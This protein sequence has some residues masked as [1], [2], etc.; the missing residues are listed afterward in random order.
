MPNEGG[1][2]N[3]DSKFVAIATFLKLSGKEHQIHDVQSFT[4]H[5]V[6]KIVKIGNA[7]KSHVTRLASMPSQA[8]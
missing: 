1:S 6:G 8:C 2:R 4:Y 7:S 3:L 5:F